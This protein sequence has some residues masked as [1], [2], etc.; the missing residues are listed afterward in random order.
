MTRAL[1]AFPSATLAAMLMLLPASATRAADTVLGLGAGDNLIVQDS[2]ATVTRFGIAESTGNLTRNGQLFVHT[3]AAI[4]GGSTFVGAGAGNPSTSGSL[5]TAFGHEALASNTAGDSNS[6]FGTRALQ[7]DTGGIYN[8][9]F[10]SFALYYTDGEKLGP[11]GGVN[12]TGS[13][14]SAFGAW[15]MVLNTTGRKNSALGFAALYSNTTGER[16]TALGHEAMRYNQT[17]DGNA[18]VGDSALWR[19]EGNDNVAMGSSALFNHTTGNNNVAIGAR[20]LQA[21]FLAYPSTGSNNTV[22]GAQALFYGG[23]AAE[24]T[25]VGVNALAGP[26]P[27]PSTA[28]AGN[29]AVGM[30]ALRNATGS[31]NVAVGHSAGIDQD[32]GSDN[33][34]L[35]NAGVASESGQ[36]RIGN[37]ADHSAAFVAGIHGASVDGGTDMAVF[38]DGTGKLGTVPSSIRFK[39]SVRDLGSASQ[40]LL[41]LRAV[42]FEYKRDAAHGDAPRR[43]GLIAEEVDR[44]APDLVIH[45]DDGR[46]FAVRYEF[47]T[48]MLLNELQRQESRIAAHRHQLEVQS[49]RI[50]ELQERLDELDSAP[51]ETAGR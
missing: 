22:V 23:S 24:N 27:G 41:K 16:N 43:Y 17:G 28:A 48:P 47:L 35:A 40:A 33:V 21:P 14:N 45:D 3:T 50:A 2:T 29:T 39:E 26:S 36:I 9:A 15:A 32:T 4:S 6:A 37:S 8:S 44:V 13:W 51:S 46:P 7:L 30:N 11:G 34:Y 49:R 5:N 42:S 20:A 19:N 31:G 1:P 12:S 18:A 38:V 10:G 25:A